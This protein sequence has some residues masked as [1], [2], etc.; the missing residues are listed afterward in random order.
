MEGQPMVEVRAVHEDTESLGSY[1]PVP[2]F[3]ILPV[4]AFIVRAE[5]PLL[6][7][8]GAI[9]MKDAFMPA[10]RSAI[11]PADIRWLWLT[12]TD[13]DHIGSL[14]AIMAE[15]PNARIITTF[16]GTGKL[17]LFGF[18]VDRVYLVNPGQSM[19]IGDREIVAIKPPSFDAPESTGF[20]DSKTRAFFCVDCFGALMSEPAATAADIPEAQLRDGLVTWATVDAPWLQMVDEERF[21]RSLEIVRQL[22]ASVVLSS[23]LPPARGMTKTLLGLLREA[24]DAPSFI[25]PDQ[26]ALERMMATM[27]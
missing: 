24:H 18:P 21:D 5:Q 26:A 1:V 16:L 2:G 17:G 15:A 13:P 14:A 3:G 10:L 6:V 8:T 9:V 25:G 20:I 22:D 12:H 27:A 11:D 19:S 7:D 4:N 23:H